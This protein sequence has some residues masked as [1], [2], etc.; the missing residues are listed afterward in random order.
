MEETMQKISEYIATYGLSLLSAI[1]IFII[2]KWLVGVIANGV[3][4]LMNKQKVDSTLAVFVKNFLRYVLLMF[5]ILAVL[6]KVGIQTTS[7]IA[8]LGAAGNFPPSFL[9]SLF[10]TVSSFEDPSLFVV[11]VLVVV[12]LTL[13]D[14]S[15]FG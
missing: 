3:E 12:V 5:V 6:A 4:K 9:S 1:A 13:L 7:F 2:G 15:L 8:V 10:V 14:P 11:R